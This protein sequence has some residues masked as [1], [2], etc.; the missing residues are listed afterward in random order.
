MSGGNPFAR[1]CSDLENIFS[2]SHSAPA[3]LDTG[4]ESSGLDKVY[5]SHTLSK[6][7]MTKINE[8]TH[9]SNTFNC[10]WNVFNSFIPQIIWKII[11]I[12]KWFIA[13]TTMSYF[14][15]LQIESNYCNPVSKSRLNF[16]L[17]PTFSVLYANNLTHVS[18]KQAQNPWRC[19]I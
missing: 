1:E 2:E 16:P 9:C 15:I 6:I 17:N 7:V 5:T 18:N 13:D 4:A 14:A 3:S 11:Q 19:S 12:L 10:S 8:V